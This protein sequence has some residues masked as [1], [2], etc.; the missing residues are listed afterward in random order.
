V[1]VLVAVAA[2]V[3][4]FAGM[5]VRA[6]IKEHGLHRL[7]W[8]WFSGHHLD[9]RHRTNAG[10]FEPGTKVLHPTGRAS[11]W[12]HKPRGH[13]AL[14]RTGC[15]LGVLLT[16]YGLLTARA[17]T[18]DAL[19]MAG[20]VMTILGIWA[21]VRAVQ[22]WQHRRQWVRPLHVALTPYIDVPLAA[23]PESWLTVPRGFSEL[24]NAE[25]RIALPKGFHASAEARRTITDIAVNKLA[26][27][28]ASAEFRMS[29]REPVC[30]ITTT[31]PPPNTVR[32][33]E[34]KPLMEAASPTAPV[35]GIG[36]AR[37]IVTADLNSDSPHIAVSAGSGGGKS[38]LTRTVVTQGLHNGDVALMLDVKRISQR[39]AKGLPNIR[40]CRTTEEIHNALISLTPELDRRNDIVDTLSDENGDL[41]DNVNIGPRFWLICEEL[42]ATAGRLAAHWRK[43]KPKDGPAVSPAI[44][45][46]NDYLFMGRALKM[47]AIGIA[48]MLSAKATGGPEA[49]ENFAIRCLTRYTLNAWKMLVPEVWPMPA[50]TRH[51]GRWQIVAG[52]IAHETQV[53]F[54]TPAEAREW[55]TSG[56]VTPFPALYEVVDGELVE[57]AGEARPVAALT[58]SQPEL[59]HDHLREE[60]VSLTGPALRVVRDDGLVGLREAV[61]SGIFQSVTL[62]T[63]RW[64][65]ANDS[66]FPQV[67]DKRGQELLYSADE[68]ERWEAN[69]ERSSND[70]AV[71]E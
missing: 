42:N 13:R 38:V 66:E 3:V 35:L 59:G 6:M 15:T 69:R 27:E 1:I 21:A 56:I 67:K 68:L 47:H 9:G 40:Y 12:A 2:L 37:S 24:D 31:V 53:G 33:A 36:R 52:G 45:A 61:E 50:K 4:A 10:W 7:T 28:Q 17:A 58:G 51:V 70:Q 43:I 71:G 32:F 11:R 41:P 14:I 62:H 16:L 25:I 22:S 54:L 34:L 29:G 57:P 48:Q 49:R 63:A 26:L 44:E 5:A 18:V 39:W 23:R 8:R 55:A 60:P 64:A 46:L 65:R 20:L 30:V 19:L